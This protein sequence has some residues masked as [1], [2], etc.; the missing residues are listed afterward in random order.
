MLSPL[1]P[2]LI[3]HLVKGILK[4]KITFIDMRTLSPREL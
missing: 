3:K 4:L 2:L 1:F